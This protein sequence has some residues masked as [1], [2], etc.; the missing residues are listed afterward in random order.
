MNKIKKLHLVDTFFKCGLCFFIF[1]HE[2]PKNFKKHTKK[3]RN[4]GTKVR[5]TVSCVVR[6][7]IYVHCPK[8]FKTPWGTKL[9]ICWRFGEVLTSIAWAIDKQKNVTDGQTDWQLP[10]LYK[11]NIKF[12]QCI[13]IIS[14][15]VL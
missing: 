6:A 4:K 3:S 12:Q 8:Q 1:S 14:I 13:F 7:R 9:Y 2:M 10:N 15:L 5:C 11:D